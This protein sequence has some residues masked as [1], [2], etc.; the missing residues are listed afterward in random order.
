MRYNQKE[1][2]PTPACHDKLG[3]L[4]SVGDIIVYGHALGRCAAL[5]IGKVLALKALTS[6][7]SH[8][9]EPEWRITVQGVDEGWSHTGNQKT[10]CKKGT[11]MYPDRIIVL[12]HNTM[13][14]PDSAA[15]YVDV[16]V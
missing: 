13:A 3:A 6:P 14:L 11:L 1:I 10:L 5:R 4:I 9:S 7:Y 16:L 12:G 2:V 8:I 15:S